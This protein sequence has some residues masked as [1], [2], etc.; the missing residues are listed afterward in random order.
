[1]NV[2]NV[3]VQYGRHAILE[4]IEDIV[5]FDT[6]GGEYGPYMFSLQ[7]LEDYIDKYKKERDVG[8]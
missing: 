6:S 3:E 1:M 2:I 7:Y 5:I 4:I 8:S